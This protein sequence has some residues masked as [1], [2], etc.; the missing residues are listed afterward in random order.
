[1]RNFLD[2]VQRKGHWILLFLFEVIALSLLFNGK[3]YH[4]FLNLTFSNYVVGSIH[5]I[6][7]NIEGYLYLKQT[8]E[9]LL[10]QNAVLENRYHELKRQV[11]YAKARNIIPKVFNL[12]EERS[13][14]SLD[15]TTARVLFS[16]VTDSFNK[17]IINKGA[18]AGIKKDM[19]VISEQG[20]VGIV[21][22]VSENYSVVIPLI[23]PSL[24]LSCKLKNTGHYGY[25]TWDTPRETITHLSNLPSYVS[26]SK[27]DSIVTSGF[28]AIFPEGIYVGKVGGITEL[29][30]GRTQSS[31]NVPV[32]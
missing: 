18:D 13:A 26:L 11:E 2:F 16:S 30:G 3:A 23:N 17:I 15:I 32:V 8:N 14:A 22:S 9:R 12:D 20:V 7:A 19:G 28:S 24:K 31:T 29:D 5:N 6:S 25:L 10:E 1:M 27:G 4:K 21:F